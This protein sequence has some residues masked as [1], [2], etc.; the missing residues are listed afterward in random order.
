MK[1][2]L[3]LVPPTLRSEILF[4]S[5]QILVDHLSS[6]LDNEY[7]GFDSTVMLSGVTSGKLFTKISDLPNSE[8]EDVHNRVV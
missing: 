3:Q 2:M 5:S 4:R 1:N 8:T 7:G 6:G